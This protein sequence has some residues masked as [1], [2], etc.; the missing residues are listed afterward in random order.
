MFPSWKVMGKTIFLHPSFLICKPRL[1]VRD[2]TELCGLSAQRS[3][4]LPQDLIGTSPFAPIILPKVS[5]CRPQTSPLALSTFLPYPS[6]WCQRIATHVP[7]NALEF[8]SSKFSAINTLIVQKDENETTTEQMPFPTS[9]FC[10][11]S[12]PPGGQPWSLQ[13]LRPCPFMGKT[14]STPYTMGFPYSMT[15]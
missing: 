6:L 4:C 12:Q 14:S 13:S 11:R 1:L 3:L 9:C 2:R 15:L 7:E 5:S 10:L 8:S